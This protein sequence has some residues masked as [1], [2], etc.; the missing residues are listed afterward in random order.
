MVCENEEVMAEVP[1]GFRFETKR[2]LDYPAVGDFV[3][4][5]RDTSSNGS[6]VL[7]RKSLL[8]KKA[9]ETANE[10]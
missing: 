10:E 7:S 6:N 2:L 1:R 9:A 3:M 4:L 8:I 5:D